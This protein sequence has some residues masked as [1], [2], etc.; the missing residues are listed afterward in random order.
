M[1]D[2]NQLKLLLNLLGGGGGVEGKGE[3]KTTTPAIN[4]GMAGFSNL[5]RAV[6]KSNRPSHGIRYIPE[7]EDD[8]AVR[9]DVA[10]HKFAE[11]LIVSTRL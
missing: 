6:S 8:R 9:L 2:E 11:R 10:T 4:V 5:V 3:S 7:W 1:V